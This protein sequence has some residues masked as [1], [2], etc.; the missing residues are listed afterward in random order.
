MIKIVSDSTCDLSKE[1]V[2]KYDIQI[3]PLHILLG[4]KEYLDG[5]EI[6]PDEIYAW[7]DKNEDTPKTS[8]V[9]FVEAM[10]QTIGTPKIIINNPYINTLLRFFHQNI[11]NTAPHES[12]GNNKIFHKD[13]FFSFFQFFQHSHQ[14]IIAH[15]KILCLN[16]SI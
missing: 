10:R 2:K 14:K 15:T 8:A 16:I 7:A 1:L 4:E 9:G 5:V 3:V 11:F 13:I 12:I 6:F